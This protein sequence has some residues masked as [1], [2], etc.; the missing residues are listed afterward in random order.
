MPLVRPANS[1]A[2]PCRSC[3]FVGI[4]LRSRLIGLL[5]GGLH[6]NMY[7]CIYIYI[8]MYVCIYIYIY[9]LYIYMQYNIGGSLEISW[10]AQ[11]YIFVHF[12]H[13]N[14][15]PKRSKDIFQHLQAIPKPCSN[16]HDLKKTGVTTPS[17]Q[18]EDPWESRA[19]K[20]ASVSSHCTGGFFWVTREECWRNFGPKRLVWRQGWSSGRC[21]GR[22]LRSQGNPYSLYIT[23]WMGSKGAT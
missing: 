11:F 6:H 10:N 5:L 22:E 21:N 16:F 19:M 12:E 14:V 1:E 13:R 9:I 8:Y 3:F 18:T 7:V 2:F 4:L 20:N 23:Y 17:L 15:G